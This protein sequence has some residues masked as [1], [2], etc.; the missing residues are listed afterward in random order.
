MQ[1]RK[2]KK[3]FGLFLLGTTSLH[4]VI[5]KSIFLDISHASSKKKRNCGE[6]NQGPE[7]PEEWGETLVVLPWHSNVHAEQTTH[8]IQRNEYRRDQS[9]LA[10]DLVGSVPLGE[11][12][13]RELGQVIAVGPGQHLFEVPQAGHHRD[14]VILNI[15]KIEADVH[16]RGDFV[17]GVAP[18][19]ETSENICFAT[20]KLHETH[21][22][23]ADHSNLS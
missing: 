19:C 10:Q 4:T 12:V 11:I 15:A 7:N 5:P 3:S 13:D 16:A 22:I 23:L 21:D 2:Q 17:V 8:Q 1:K 9:D 14:N 6:N 20:E 18:L